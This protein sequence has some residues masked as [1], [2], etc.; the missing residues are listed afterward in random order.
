M[1]KFL[2]ATDAQRC[3]HLIIEFGAL[4][5]HEL[6]IDVEMEVDTDDEHRVTDLGAGISKDPYVLQIWYYDRTRCSVRH[7]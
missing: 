1:H 4:H 3:H 2:V 7:E 6:Y 5:P